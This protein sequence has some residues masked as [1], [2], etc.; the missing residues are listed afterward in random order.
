M[1]NRMALQPHE[2]TIPGRVTNHPDYGL[3]L[4]HA[5]DIP[6]YAIAYSQNEIEK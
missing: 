4:D 6:H 5:H 1:I 2:S 3:D